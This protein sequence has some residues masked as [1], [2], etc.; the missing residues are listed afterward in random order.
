MDYIILIIVGIVG[1]VLGTYFGRRR[2]SKLD[3]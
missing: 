1:V 2:K 3:N